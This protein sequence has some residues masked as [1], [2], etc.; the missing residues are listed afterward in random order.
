MKIL[1]ALQKTFDKYTNIA[2][3]KQ[4]IANGKINETEFKEVKELLKKLIE[5]RKSNEN[6]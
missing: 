2:K 6:C 1:D 5:E 4:T 3:L